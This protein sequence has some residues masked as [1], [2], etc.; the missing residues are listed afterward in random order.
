[1]EMVSA[2]NKRNL[3]EVLPVV[4]PI[5]QAKHDPRFRGALI[6]K[7]ATIHWMGRAIACEELPP[8]AVEAIAS[9][10]LKTEAVIVWVDGD[11]L[12]FEVVNCQ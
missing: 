7:G 12:N 9:Y 3:S 11:R 5:F 1:M 10:D 6:A 4:F 2:K 8:E